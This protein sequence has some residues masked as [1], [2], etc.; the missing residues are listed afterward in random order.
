MDNWTPISEKLPPLGAAI[1]VTVRS[2]HLGRALKGEG[3]LELRYPV[4][5]LERSYGE[6]YGFYHYDKMLSP[7]YDDVIAW[8]PIPGPYND[9]GG[10][11]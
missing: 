1:I 8:M 6:G 9:K 11:E 5:Y 2:N 4:H 10:M 7:A 3:R